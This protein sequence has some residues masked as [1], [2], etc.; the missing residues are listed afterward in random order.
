MQTIGFC[1]KHDRS[2][3]L[4]LTECRTTIHDAT[5]RRKSEGNEKFDTSIDQD[6]EYTPKE[7]A[8]F[9]FVG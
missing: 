5:R 1:K 3:L 7:E 2:L 9:N 8:F 6:R 4:N